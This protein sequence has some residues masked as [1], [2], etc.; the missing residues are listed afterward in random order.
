MSPHK[1]WFGFHQSRASSAGGREHLEHSWHKYAMI[2]YDTLSCK[3]LAASDAWRAGEH[4]SIA[5]CVP[6]PKRFIH[7]MGTLGT[8]GNPWEPKVLISPL[9]PPLLKRETRDKIK[10]VNPVD[11]SLSNEA[12]CIGFTLKSSAI[13]AKASVTWSMDTYATHPHSRYVY[14]S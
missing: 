8:H 4:V 10:S 9:L 11:K 6:N 7:L 1:W 2:D 13:F 12:P 3:L 5:T 14:V